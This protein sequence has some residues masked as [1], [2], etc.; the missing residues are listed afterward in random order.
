MQLSRL[1]VEGGIVHFGARSEIDGD[2]ASDVSEGEESG[3]IAD[4][5]AEGPDF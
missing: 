2:I 1:V 4:A 3:I 5:G